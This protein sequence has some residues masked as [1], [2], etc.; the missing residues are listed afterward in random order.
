MARFVDEVAALDLDDLVDRIGELKA[1]ILN[2]NR[3]VSV[4]QVSAIDV[5]D[6][7]HAASPD[8][9]ERVPCR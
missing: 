7:G 3:G 5:D 4:R 9:A 1:A 2:V 6:A 8:K